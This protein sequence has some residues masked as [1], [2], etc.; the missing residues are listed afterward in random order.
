V[1]FRFCYFSD[2]LKYMKL[3]CRKCNS[4]IPTDQVDIHEGLARCTICEEYF[5][6]ADF[7]RDDE[8]LR[9]IKKPFYSKVSIDQVL[10]AHLVTIPPN[11]W[12]GTAIF[13]FLFALIWNGVSWPVLFFTEAVKEVPSIFF[14]VFPLIGLLT[15]FYF[16]FI[17][18]G[19]VYIY[20][21]QQ[22]IELVWQLF[23][24][25][26]RRIRQTANL[27]KIT[28]SVVYTKN[29][30]PV[31]G[32]ALLFN[33]ERRVVFGSGLKEEERKWLIGELY[34]MKIHYQDKR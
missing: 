29:Y 28:E 12:N 23:G 22:T 6:V 3:I 26:F 17:L 16:F 1:S 2:N 34:E 33:K 15:I 8:E 10:Q 4:E 7:L 13:M 19:I 30:Q 27:N 9:R 11:G 21:N 25:R 24:I 20:F 5:K 14:I 18:R 31:Y 32:I